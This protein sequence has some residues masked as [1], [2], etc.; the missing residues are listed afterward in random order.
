MKEI[1]MSG[2]PRYYKKP[3]KLLKQKLRDKT[4]LRT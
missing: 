3:L 4:S 1:E 2:G